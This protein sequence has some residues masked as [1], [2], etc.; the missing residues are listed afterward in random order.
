VVGIVLTMAYLFKMMRGIFYG[1]TVR[2]YSHAHDAVAF[3]DRMPLLLMIACSI[4]FGLFPGHFYHVIRSGVDPLIARVTKIAPLASL[5]NEKPN[6]FS[7]DFST[8]YSALS[9]QS[10]SKP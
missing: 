8:Q 7:P 1:A 4:T 10:K 9:T 6:Q 2:E 3:V 5:E